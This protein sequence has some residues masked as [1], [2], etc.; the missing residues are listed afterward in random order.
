MFLPIGSAL[1]TSV[2]QIFFAFAKN[3]T[4]RAELQLPDTVAPWSIK[5]YTLAGNRIS[6]ILQSLHRLETPV[7]KQAPYLQGSRDIF[8]HAEGSHGKI[9]GKTL[10][11]YN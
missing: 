3:C 2:T 10:Q 6:S 8:A 9:E 7:G 11:N 4:G 1:L 5:H